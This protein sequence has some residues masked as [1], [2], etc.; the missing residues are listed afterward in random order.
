METW[1]DIPDYEGIYQASTFGRIRSAEG[2]TTFS[3]LHGERKWRS[4]ILKYRGFNRQTGHRVSLWR[5]GSHKDWLVARLIA[6]TF[7]GIPENSDMTVNHID[8]NRFNNNITNLEWLSLADNIRH[9]F[10]TGLMPTQKSVY[11]I[12]SSGNVNLFR[13]MSRASSYLGRCHGYISGNI[14][15]GFKIESVSGE[16]YKAI[17]K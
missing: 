6:I 3:V 9:A 2:K 7:L 11:L 4:K 5:D 12:D 13:S 17:L 1:K 16:Q 15:K 10:N 8:G 14:S